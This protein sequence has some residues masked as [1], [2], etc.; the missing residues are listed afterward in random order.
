[1][2]RGDEPRTSFQQV[3][4]RSLQEG[5]GRAA[6]PRNSTQLS[7]F[8]STEASVGPSLRPKPLHCL[9]VLM[10]ACPQRQRSVPP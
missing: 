8:W 7:S 6:D 9:V 3:G 10:G 1:M 5:L 4:C 2:L